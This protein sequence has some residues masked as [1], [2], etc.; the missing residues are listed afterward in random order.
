MVSWGLVPIHWPAFPPNPSPIETVWNQMKDI[1]EELDPEVHRN[2]ARLRK[3]VLDAWESITDAEI[4]GIIHNP[5]SGMHA[6]CLA[7]IRAHGYYT[8]F[9]IASLNFSSDRR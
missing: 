7:I 3:A 4:Y 8:K 1:L 2:Y 5:E 6:R 9:S